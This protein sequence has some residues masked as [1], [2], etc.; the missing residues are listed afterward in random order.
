VNTQEQLW[1][2]PDWTCPQCGWTNMAIRSSALEADNL[3]TLV[4]SAEWEGGVRCPKA[5]EK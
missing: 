2:D 3:A 5:N 4:G 1:L